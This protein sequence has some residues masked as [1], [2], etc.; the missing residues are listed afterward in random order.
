[1]TVV[2]SVRLHAGARMPQLG[3]GVYLVPAARTRALVGSAVSIG[4]RLIDTAAMYRNERGVG[5][6]VTEAG[7]RR[8][9]VFVTTKLNNDAHG[10]DAALRAFEHSRSEL[11]LDYVDLYLIHWP[12]PHLNRYVDTWR[13][14]IKLRADGV[15]RS[16]GVSNFEPAQLDRLRD[17]TGV[18]PAVNQ[19]ELHPHRIRQ[20]LRAYHAAHDIVT[21]AWGPLDR[22]AAL[23]AGPVIALAEK[24]GKT[25]AQ[26]VLRWHLQLG[27]V[28]I[29]KTA[30]PARLRENFEVFDFEL[31]ADDVDAVSALGATRD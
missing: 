4:Y 10:Y 23:R 9:D 14:L 19:V 11:G 5:Q 24:Y 17:E 25:P 15:V 12:L 1:L 3:L 26:I 27:N 29:P 2:P 30:T 13:A 16:I 8:D 18:T 22:G 21:E 6:A 31:D 20:R 7:L 28:V